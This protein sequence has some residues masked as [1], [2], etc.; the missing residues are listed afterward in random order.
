MSWLARFRLRNRD[1]EIAEEINT[2]LDMATRERIARGESPEEARLAALREFGN[3]ALI[4]E[5]TRHVWSWTRLEQLAQDLRFGA[6]ILWHSP[7]L[8]A[9]A[10]FLVALVIGGNTTIYSMVNSVLTSPAAGVTA[11]RLVAIKQVDPGAMLT[12]PFFSYP[13]Y[14]DYA[15]GARTLR[16]LVAWSGER[17]TIGVET[18]NYAVLGGLVTPNYFDILGIDLNAGRGFR[19]ADDTLQDG[20]VAV[21]S[22]RLWRD[23][24]QQAADIV[25]RSMMVNANPATVV[26]VAAP[27][28]R[29]PMLTADEDVWVPIGAYYAAIADTGV[30]NNRAQRVVVMVGQLAPGASLRQARAEL[31]TLWAQ[32]PAA[33][34]TDR[35][36]TTVVA[37][38][39]SA[40]ALLPMADIAPR[41]LALFSVVTLLTLLIVSA[42]VANLLLGRAVERQRDTAVRQ[43]LGASRIRIVRMLLAEG[44]AIAMTAWVAASL[45][46]WWTSRTMARVVEPRPG[47]LPDMRPDWSTA[48]YAMLL[49]L[50]AMIAFTTAPGVRAWR[51][52]ALPLLKSGEHSVAR[53]R[54][55]LSSTLVVLQF[56]F[57]VLLL[58]SAGLAYRSLSLFDSGEV[59]F[60]TDNLLLVTVRAVRSGAFARSEPS[61]A[62]REMARGLLE[63]VRERLTAVPNVE[64]VTYSR[65]VPGPYL[66][67]TTAVRQEGRAEPAHA[68]VRPVGP[69]YLNTLGLSPSMGRELTAIDHRGA[70]RSAVI[71]R[72]LAAQLWPQGSPIGETLLLG[73]EQQPVEIVGIAPDAQFDGPVHEAQPRY[74]LVAEQQHTGRPAIDPTFFIRHRGSLEALAPLV[75]RAIAEVDAG[76]PIVAMTT[77]RQRIESVSILERQ[78]ATL[79]TWFSAMSLVIAALGQY[80]VAMFNMRRRKRDFGVRLALGASARQIQ[81]GVVHESLRL[82]TM[83]L[84]IGLAL[85]AAAGTA[86]RSVLFGVT[87]T[88][89]P[90][91]AGVV[92]VL[93]ITSFVASYLPAWRAGR[94]NVVDA[95]RQE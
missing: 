38:N 6:R 55:R 86:F 40:A 4:R 28:F 64:S 23:R 44:V 91:Y 46:A 14:R 19:P 20:L 18:G 13:S 88:D 16:G 33:S 69:D 77:M 82:T 35:T 79:L 34:P 17:L 10:V 54:S 61:A 90:T 62:E 66:L 45:L 83:G 89:P 31:A 29:G 73:D 93:A 2:H 85:S 57:S 39:Y 51:Q 15:S 74:V 47:L 71:N 53:G 11:D 87:P 58:T 94:V 36:T 42:N 70:V 5:S 52:Q 22:D 75:G 67:A 81:R 43:S 37:T 76:L 25:G 95:L 27:G 56:A 48:A 72:Q 24:F 1:R 63:R 68:Y 32:I 50:L 26:G 65:R 9:M 59:G 30:L 12:D 41:F 80:A 60:E 7:A 49:A 78:V 92:L 21:I 3:V 8:S 84:L